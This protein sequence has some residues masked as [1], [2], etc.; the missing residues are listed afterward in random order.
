MIGISECGLRNKQGAPS[1]RWLKDGSDL[2]TARS[3][4][5][6]RRSA[7]DASAWPRGQHE[8]LLQKK[9]LYTLLC[10][11]LGDVAEARF[12]VVLCLPTHGARQE[13]RLGQFVPVNILKF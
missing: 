3:T 1:R 11:I 13:A 2:S 9:E 12:R 4:S 5:T 8:R 10:P 6:A 7:T